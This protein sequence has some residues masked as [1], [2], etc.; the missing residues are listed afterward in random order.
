MPQVS[1]VNLITKT[2]NLVYNGLKKTANAKTKV[3]VTTL[4]R[5]LV[6]DTKKT[7]FQR[8][9]TLATLEALAYSLFATCKITD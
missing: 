4:A 7:M 1:Y 8:H 5:N 6:S 2:P 9:Y 3:A